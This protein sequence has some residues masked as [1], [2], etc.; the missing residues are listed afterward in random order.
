MTS[1]LEAVAE[2]AD[3]REGAEGVRRLLL[4]L[5]RDE[6]VGVRPLAR[7]VGLPIPVAVAVVGELDKEGLVE[8][9]DDGLRFTG[10]GRDLAEELGFADRTVEDAYPVEVPDA[11]GDVLDAVREV[12]DR[13]GPADTTIDQAFATPATAARRAL[14]LLPA[15]ALEGRRV[16]FVGDSDLVSVACAA[17]D[18]AG[19]LVV[20][21]RDDRLADLL[22]ETVTFRDHDLR[23]PLPDDL[24]DRFDAV[25]TDPPFTGAGVELFVSRGLEAL[26]KGA[27]RTVLCSVARPDPDRGLDLVERF[28]GLGLAVRAW[29]PGWNRYEGAHVLGSRGDLVHLVTTGR[30]EPSVDGRFDGAIYSREDDV[31]VRRYRCTGCDTVVDVGRDPPTIE[32]LKEEGCPS[33]G[34]TS[35]AM[36]GR[37]EE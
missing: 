31:P 28:A 6:P 26:G 27:D 8:R 34:G 21:D 36:Q 5:H 1:V 18:V 35:F 4:A 23:D 15:G 9:V 25:V 29:L 19:E 2:R 14:V 20:V 30:T 10:S 37:A 12:A 32:A 16:L 3:L 13:R 17:L 7:R 22:P 11:Y 24:R 33:C